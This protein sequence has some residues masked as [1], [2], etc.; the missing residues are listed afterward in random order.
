MPPTRLT[1]DAAIRRA[2]PTPLRSL[3]LPPATGTRSGTRIA[4]APRRPTR[5]PQ[6][7]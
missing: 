1:S 7:S 3:C 6:G 5:Q 4:A 2:P